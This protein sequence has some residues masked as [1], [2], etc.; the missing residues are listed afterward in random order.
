MFARQGDQVDLISIQVGF[1]F[2]FLKMYLDF[3]PCLIALFLLDAA[4]FNPP[5]MPMSQL[6][7]LG[8][9]EYG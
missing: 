5:S 2:A 9:V 6:L 7:L 3:H 1:A 8:K 4:M